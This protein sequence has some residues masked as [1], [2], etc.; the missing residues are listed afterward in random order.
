MA[1]LSYRV[2]ILITFFGIGLLGYFLTISWSMDEKAYNNISVD[3]FIKMMNQKDF[4]LI[5]VHIPYQGE[6]DKTDLLIPF[7]ALDQHK[8]KLPSDKDV[9][10]VVYCMAGPMGFIAAERLVGMGYTQVKHFRGGMRDWTKNGK[11]LVY[12]TKGDM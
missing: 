10:I 1:K 6:I 12:R 9:K 5:N 3:Q 4:I 11:Q 7:N 8:N 2:G